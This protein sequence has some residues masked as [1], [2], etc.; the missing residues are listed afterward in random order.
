MEHG[1]PPD[2]TGRHSPAD[3]DVIVIG[4][5]VAGLT[6]A[7]RLRQEKPDC[8]VLVLEAK[9]RVG[10]RTLS[11]E[12]QGAHGKDVWDLGGQWLGSTQH[13]LHWL[14]EE[15]GLEKYPQY[16]T[17]KK[18]MLLGNRGI[19]SYNSSIPSMSLAALVD[20][21]RF[22]TLTDRLAASVPLDDPM[23]SPYAKVYDGTTM[24]S[25]VRQ[26]T[27]TQ[28]A[29]D[30]IEVS[31][32]IINGAP[33][34][35]M[36]VL[37]FMHYVASAGGIRNLV[38]AEG[39]ANNGF[40]IKGGAQ[41]ISKLLVE[42]IGQEQ[43]LLGQP[44][45]HIDQQEADS[46]TVVTAAGKAFTCRYVVVAA[47]IH[48]STDI[49]YT[50]VKPLDRINLARLSP[51]GHLIKFIVT[52]PTAFWRED[53][54]SGEIVSNGGKPII[55]GPSSGPLHLTYD[56]TTSNGNPGIVG[57]YA[58]GREWSHID[59]DIRKQAVLDSLAEFFGSKAR[60]PLDYCEKDWALESYNGGC[61]VN[62]MTPGAMTFHKGLRTPFDRVHW[63]GTETATH[64]VG[65]ISGAVQSGMR[66]ADEVLRRLEP[67]RPPDQVLTSLDDKRDTGQGNRM[68]GRLLLVGGAVGA[69]LVTALFVKKFGLKWTPSFVRRMSKPWNI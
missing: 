36:S 20:V 40:R 38:E 41:Q 30:A 31:A 49:K 66:A 39:D 23:K 33:P 35:M 43:V 47:P 1:S 68:W 27:W 17:G 58:N 19:R 54:F 3:W 14:M 28:E 67:E 53:G 7:Y 55:E 34:R 50:P 18:L 2:L 57:F 44:V 24:D 15:L 64:H 22:L 5:G 37:Y 48:C 45:D 56:C 10:G 42:R 9:D 29:R 21:H 13:H 69:V 4:A 59:P 8:R 52:Y 26:T 12:M 61:P 6:T 65:F 62:I 16:S 46:V 63:A 11:T 32:D 51:V 25:L 60:D